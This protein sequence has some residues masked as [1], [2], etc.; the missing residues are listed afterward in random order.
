MWQCPKC[1]PDCCVAHLCQSRPVDI[2][3]YREDDYI[4]EIQPGQRGYGRYKYRVLGRLGS[5]THHTDDYEDARNWLQKCIKFW[6]Q[7]PLA[8]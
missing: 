3:K 7:T 6:E 4:H 8:E 5:P 1:T 2:P